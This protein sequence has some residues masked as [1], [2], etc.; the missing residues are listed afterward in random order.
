MDTFPLEKFLEKGP[1]VYSLCLF[2]I[3]RAKQLNAGYPA[4]IQPVVNKISN[5]ALCEIIE[6]KIRI[7]ESKA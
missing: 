4:L 3:K 7:P 2:A 1:G 5:V 6:G